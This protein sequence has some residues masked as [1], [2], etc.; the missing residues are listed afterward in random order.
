LRRG[1]RGVTQRAR[2]VP[3]CSPD[4]HVS[5]HRTAAA[6]RAPAVRRA[7]H[8]HCPLPRAPITP[9]LTLPVR[10]C[11]PGEKTAPSRE[12]DAGRAVVSS[13]VIGALGGEASAQGQAVGHVVLGLGQQSPGLDAGLSLMIGGQRQAGVTSEGPQW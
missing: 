11:V 9:C 13:S 3:R 12:E 2:A 8:E 10:L 7:S 4:K 6:F 5:A 1:A